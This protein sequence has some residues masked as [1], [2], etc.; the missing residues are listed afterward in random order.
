MLLLV[1]LKDTVILIVLPILKCLT[2]PII[3]GGLYELS[4]I[5]V[6]GLILVSMILYTQYSYFYYISCIQAYYIY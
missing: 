3:L 4:L 6:H 1:A 5:L 2:Y